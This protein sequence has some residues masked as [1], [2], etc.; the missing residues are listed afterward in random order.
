VLLIHVV[1]VACERQDPLIGLFS[2]REGALRYVNERIE[3]MNRRYE[4]DGDPGPEDAV[5]RLEWW[6]YHN[7]NDVVEEQ[8]FITYTPQAV[9]D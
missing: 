2:S 5:A 8:T 4:F 1:C 7:A 6:N 9:E 3:A